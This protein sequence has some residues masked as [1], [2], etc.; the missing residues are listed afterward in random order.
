MRRMSL[1]Y[2]ACARRVFPLLILAS[3]ELSAAS[4]SFRVTVGSE[5]T[6]SA[7]DAGLASFGRQTK[8]F[9]QVGAKIIPATT[10]TS[11]SDGGAASVSCSWKKAVPPG[12]YPLWV[13]TTGDKGVKTSVKVTD[14]FV[15]AAPSIHQISSSTV[16]GGGNLTISGSCFS[17]DASVRIGSSKDVMKDCKIQT[18]RKAVMDPV[19]GVSSVEVTVPKGISSVEGM[20]LEVASSIGADYE[21]VDAELAAPEAVT[22]ALTVGDIHETSK[23]LPQLTNFFKTF[24]Q[25]HAGMTVT[26]SAGDTLSA[27][28]RKSYEPEWARDLYNTDPAVHG[29][30][31]MELNSLL[32]FDAVTL[33][34]HDPCLGYVRYAELLAAYPQPVMASNLYKFSGSQYTPWRNGIPALP[35][36]DYLI[37]P[38][39][40]LDVA[41]IATGSTFE[42]HWTNTDKSSYKILNTL[43]ERTIGAV[44]LCSVLADIVILVTHENDLSDIIPVYGPPTP[45]GQYLENCDIYTLKDL[46]KVALIHGAHEHKN[47]FRRANYS[48]DNATYALYT[49]PIYNP[50]SRLVL[51]KSSKFFGEYAGVVRFVWDK[52]AGTTI[53][54]TLM[55]GLRGE[56]GKYLGCETSMLVEVDD[57]GMLQELDDSP[58]NPTVPTNWWRMDD[59]PSTDAAVHTRIGE[60]HGK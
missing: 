9:I 2:R 50:D 4:P 36:T 25:A 49:N 11:S 1:F 32:P 18:P 51:V 48:G 16:V 30:A 60:L 29:V 39:K 20:T 21:T 42:D 22:Y 58:W 23:Y 43:D 17:P 56:D 35:T 27:Y 54:T 34:N 12:A 37:M 45:S 5:F 41:V 46:Q 3:L 59:W 10:K 28:A 40:G 26:L 7:A 8:V 47:L 55:S 57:G 24:K 38:L 6:V 52:T 14:Y 31:M 19:S 53:S 15:V 44:R 13:E 33:G